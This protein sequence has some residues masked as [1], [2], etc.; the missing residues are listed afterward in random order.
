[1]LPVR[2]E[3]LLAGVG[4]GT[5]TS[6]PSPK[7]G[8]PSRAEYDGDPPGGE[9]GDGK[10]SMLKQL[11]R[12][13]SLPGAAAPRA[14]CGA[15]ERADRSCSS[16]KT[17]RR[18][19]ALLRAFER[20]TG[21]RLRI[22]QSG[23]AVRPQQGAP[24]VGAPRTFIGVDSNLLK[25]ALEEDLFDP[26]ESGARAGRRLI[27]HRAPVRRSSRRGVMNVDRGGSARGAPRR[28]TGMT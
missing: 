15:T 1:M 12:S 19:E 13:W 21:L 4:R 6:S 28:A 17:L 25:R 24:H 8:S 14:A 10:D 27:C 9:N 16:R 20:E 3:T 7:R 23:E 5:Q 22:R 2:A 26:Y 18:L 11:G